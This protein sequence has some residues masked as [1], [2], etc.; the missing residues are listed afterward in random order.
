MY[1]IS[2]MACV[3]TYKTRTTILI[4]PDVLVE[5]HLQGQDLKQT[6]QLE[7][8]VGGEALIFIII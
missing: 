8:W 1:V 7:E 5:L 6:T 2:K 3:I 4:G